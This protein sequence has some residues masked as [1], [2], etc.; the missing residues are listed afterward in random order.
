MGERKDL[1]YKI[2]NML[3]EKLKNEVIKNKK[4]MSLLKEL[5]ANESLLK[6][7]EEDIS[8]KDLIT[9]YNGQSNEQ[10]R[11]MISQ[12]L[13]D[14]GEED[15]K[16]LKDLGIKELKDLEDLGEECLKVFS[17]H[18]EGLE[19]ECLKELKER[20]YIS[21]YLEKLGEKGLKELEEKGY[22][23]CL[24]FLKEYDKPMYKKVI[25]DY[26]T[27]LKR[28]GFLETEEDP[29]NKED[30]ILKLTEEGRKYSFS[31]LEV[32]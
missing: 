24:D 10:S 31:E 17:Q 9:K 23:S 27:S 19:E 1:E 5:K 6:D 21:R 32:Q 18:L 16:K 2:L 4:A 13:E 25:I 7:L 3:K 22:I 20:R 14:L 26:L 15:L 12:Y 30:L 28:T 11:K 8:Y 29:S